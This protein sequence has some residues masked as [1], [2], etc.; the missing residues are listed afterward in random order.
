MIFMNYNV[1]MNSTQ[2]KPFKKLSVQFLISYIIVNNIWWKLYIF[3]HV[4][5]Q[6]KNINKHRERGEILHHVK[7]YFMVLMY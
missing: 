7:I 6:K 3:V 2:P 5:I 4:K 1:N